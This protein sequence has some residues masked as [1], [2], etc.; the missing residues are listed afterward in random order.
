MVRLG[1]RLELALGLME[2]LAFGQHEV[3]SEIHSFL[4]H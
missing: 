3:V 2:E 4:E 1:I